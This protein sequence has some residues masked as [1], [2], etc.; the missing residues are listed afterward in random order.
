MLELNGFSRRLERYFTR[1]EVLIPRFVQ[2]ERTF[3]AIKP[4]GVQRSLV[5]NPNTPSLQKTKIGLLICMF[6]E[7]MIFMFIENYFKAKNNQKRRE[8]LNQQTNKNEVVSPFVPLH[9]H[10][11][12]DVVFDYGIFQSVNRFAFLQ[13]ADIIARFEKK[14]YK[15]VG[16]KLVHPTKEFAEKHYDDLKARPF[17]NGL[18]DFLSSGP[19]VAMVSG[20]E[21]F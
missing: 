7:N 2:V 9:R 10:L 8:D 11:T 21:L 4:D 13:I 3:I 5:T 15:L 17:F 20:I 16:I 18:T 12:F 1:V 14:G 19:V 6:I